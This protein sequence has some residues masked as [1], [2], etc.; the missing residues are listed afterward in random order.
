MTEVDLLLRIGAASVAGALVGLE[1]TY[2]GRAA[3]LRTYAL[4]AMGAAL[5]VAIAVYAESWTSRGTGDPTRVVQGVVTGIGFLGAGVII[6]E[7][8]SVRGLTTAASIWV[9]AAIGVAF[10]VGLFVPGALATLLTWVAL[11]LLHRFEGRV[12]V[13]SLVHCRVGFVRGESFDEDGLRRMIESNGFAIDEFSV[14]LNAA[15]RT[16]EYEFVLRSARVSGML[17]LERA[18]LVEPA[19]SSFRLTPARD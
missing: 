7:G 1:R 12:P 16:L 18:L 17:D 2:R 14:E 6:R 4:V 10:G 3:G 19:V 15:S 8:F 13:Q 9:V 5:V 11:D